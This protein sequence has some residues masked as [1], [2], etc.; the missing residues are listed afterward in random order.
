M[1]YSY[2]MVVDSGFAP[3]PFYGYL[4]LATCKPY[5]RRTKDEG[6]YV[7]GF[8]SSR[9]DDKYNNGFEKLIYIMKVTKK[10]SYAEYH[11]DP[12]FKKKIPNNKSRRS[13]AGDNIYQLK[14]R[15][16]TQVAT[17]NH[18]TQGEM[19]I[20]MQCRQVLISDEF[21]YFGSKPINIDR[22]AINKPKVQSAYGVRT[23]DLSEIEKLWK[24]LK[25]KY[26]MNH[27]LNDPHHFDHNYTRNSEV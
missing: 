4:T 26:K 25:S 19:E 2:K 7:A 1:L 14:N 11:E 9:L 23:S 8:T 10:M 18:G 24:Y 21:F 13:R 27:V 12:K 15:C 17:Q 22:F 6:D 3:N 5:I 20:D 16:Y